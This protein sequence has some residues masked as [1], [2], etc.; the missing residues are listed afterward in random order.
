[1]KNNIGEIPQY[2]VKNSHPAI[3][4]PDVFDLVQN[5]METKTKTGQ[6]SVNFFSGKIKCG[7]C[8]N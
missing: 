1:M 7:E 6:S 5:I 2:Y 3:I 8:G 4:E